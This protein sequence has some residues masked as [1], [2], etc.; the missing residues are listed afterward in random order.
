VAPTKETVPEY[1]PGL[2]ALRAL[3]ISVVFLYHAPGSSKLAFFEGRVGVVLFFVISGFLITNLLLRDIDHDRFSLRDYLIRRT[4]RIMPLYFAVLAAYIAI[5][6]VLGTS[7]DK[8]LFGKSL[9]WLATMNGDI[10]TSLYGVSVP[11]SVSWSIGVEEKFYLVW[12]VLLMLAGRKHGSKVATMIVVG[13]AVGSVALVAGGQERAAVFSTSPYVAVAAGCLLA[14]T[15]WKTARQRPALLVSGL[16]AL[17]L[18]QPWR[19]RI[20]GYSGLALDLVV[21]LVSIVVVRTAVAG[22]T[23]VLE[24]VLEHRTVRWVGT[25]SYG[26]YLTHKLGILITKP[27]VD[28]LGL[29]GNVWR[30]A[31]FT[32]AVALSVVLAE[33]SF[34]CIETPLRRW[35]RTVAAH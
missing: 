31:A 17:L 25:R 11:F 9:V 21:V 27:A 18:L 4:T 12:P 6:V 1:L 7:A 3:A 24:R 15:S 34:R 26:L 19:L 16:V 13:A 35:G 8:E 29:S 10:A 20:D 2:D 32:S 30:L 5:V 28:Q 22:S 33:V 14:F 23:G